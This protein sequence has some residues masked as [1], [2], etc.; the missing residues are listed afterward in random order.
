MFKNAWI[1]KQLRGGTQRLSS[2]VKRPFVCVPPQHIA[3]EVT[4]VCNLRC[5][6]CK[7]GQ[8]S[9]DRQTGL[10]DY[11][12]YRRLIDEISP[13]VR[14]ISF[15]WYGEPF[16]H[17]DFEQFVRYASAE[18]LAIRIQTNG[19]Y[20]NKCNLNYLVECNIHLISIA[21]DGLDQETYEIYR[22]GGNLDEVTAGVRRLADLRNEK[23]G[24]YPQHIRMNFIAMGHNE[25]QLE[26]VQAFSRKIGADSV[27][28]KTVHVD[29]TQDG[30]N[31]LPADPDLRRYEDDF[32]LKSGRDTQ[33][34]CPTLWRSAVISW[35]GTMGLCCIDSDCEYSPG[36]VFEDGFFNV[37]FGEKMQAYRKHVLTDKAGIPLCK[38]CHR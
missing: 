7:L 9:L 16:T 31:F 22:V 19:T 2:L 26:H 38:G 25:H 24:K 17:K 33:P 30:R 1:N 8:K 5:P 10:M 36:N 15:P 23:G 28:V 4:N 27:K 12:N 20:L 13:Y 29:R 11:D 35:D 34:G 14:R 6:M 37:W 3:I 21:I 32:R 18:G